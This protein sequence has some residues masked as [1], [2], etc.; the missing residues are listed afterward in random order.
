MGRPIHNMLFDEGMRLM[1]IKEHPIKTDGDVVA[2]D[3]MEMD[4]VLGLYEHTGGCLYLSMEPQM[5]DNL[6]LVAETRF[7]GSDGKLRV[8]RIYCEYG[9]EGLVHILAD[10]LAHFS[11]FYGI[12]LE[13]LD[14]RK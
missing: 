2:D 5:A 6:A 12:V 3:R 1:R 8:K 14:L 11:T 10:Q 13:I 4:G 9:H 7:E